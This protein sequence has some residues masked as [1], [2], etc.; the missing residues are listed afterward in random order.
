MPQRIRFNF[1]NKPVQSILYHT[2]TGALSVVT[3]RAPVLFIRFIRFLFLLT[4]TNRAKLDSFLQLSTVIQA[5]A[6]DTL[7]R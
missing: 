5:L 1:Y 4:F 7:H 6:P 2:I 3:D